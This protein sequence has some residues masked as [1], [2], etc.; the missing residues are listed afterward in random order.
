MKYRG[1]KP[2]AR[3][4]R[5]CALA[6]SFFGPALAGIA[7]SEAMHGQGPAASARSPRQQQRLGAPLGMAH[8]GRGSSPD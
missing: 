2:K 5:F 1:E 4:A 7:L 8:A 6:V 3:W